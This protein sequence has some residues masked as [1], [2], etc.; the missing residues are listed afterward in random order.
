MLVDLDQQIISSL[1]RYKIRK[2][3][4]A[5]KP[6]LEGSMAIFVQKLPNCHPKMQF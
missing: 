4:T 1:W 3:E 5:E 6:L 2:L